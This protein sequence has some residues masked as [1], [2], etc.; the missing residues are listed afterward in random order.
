ME[1]SGISNTYLSHERAS[2]GLQ[3][4]LTCPVDRNRHVL[5]RVDARLARGRDHDLVLLV[6]LDGDDLPIEALDDVGRK[7]RRTLIR[8]EY[9][10]VVSGDLGRPDVK[11]LVALAR[12][13]GVPVGVDVADGGRGVLA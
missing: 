6:A 7:R 11:V 12:V 10:A 2:T 8:P 5:L 13:V 3:R 4:L 1:I 9:L